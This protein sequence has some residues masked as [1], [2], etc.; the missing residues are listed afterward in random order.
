MEKPNDVSVYELQGVKSSIKS[1][2]L[3]NQV[4][5]L[6]PDTNKKI[7]GFL[8]MCVY[9]KTEC[10]TH[11]VHILLT[12]YDHVL[13]FLCCG[14]CSQMSCMHCVESMERAANVPFDKTKVSLQGPHPVPFRACCFIQTANNISQFTKMLEN[15]FYYL[16]FLSQAMNIIIFLSRALLVSQ[17][18]E[19]CKLKFTYHCLR[20]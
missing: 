16:H 10:H 7:T 11:H 12:K 5:L 1:D 13:F 19:P 2:H 14:P 6:Y 9:C 4:L 20:I 17:D 3:S 8:Y 15:G 18:Q